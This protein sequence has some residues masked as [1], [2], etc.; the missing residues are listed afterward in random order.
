MSDGYHVNASGVSEKY[1]EKTAK[2][3]RQGPRS[4][5]D[6][7]LALKGMN[8]PIPPLSPVPGFATPEGTR[9]WFENRRKEAHEDSSPL[10][11]RSHALGRTGLE[12]AAVGFG[13]YRIGLGFPGQRLALLQALG[14]TTNLID[15]STNYG[16][17]EAEALIG[18]VLREALASET[19]RRDQVILVTKVGYV[20]GANQAI[21]RAREDSG[22]PF[23]G[24]VKVHDEIWHCI[25]PEW[26]A[27]Q[28]TRSLE[29][30]GVETIDCLLLHNPEYFLK[31]SEDHGEYYRRIEVAFV[32]LEAEIDRGRIRRYG[33]SSNTFPEDMHASD[34]T[35]LAAVLERADAVAAQAGRPGGF[36]VIQF[37]MNVFEPGGAFETANSGRTLLELARERGLAVL[38][39]RPLNAFA[40]ER[41][42]RLADFPSHEDLDELQA[43]LQQ[44]FEKAMQVEGSCPK[45]EELNLK[46]VAWAHILRRNIARIRD[47]ENWKGIR[48]GVVLPGMEAFLAAVRG[49]EESSAHPELSAW[50]DQYEAA[51]KELVAVI[52]RAVESDAATLARRIAATLDQAA[53]ALRSSPPLTHKVIRILTGLPA[54]VC[55]LIGMRSP[56]YVRDVLNGLSHPP[57]PT[58]EA[59]DCLEAIQDAIPDFFPE[60]LEGSG[61]VGHA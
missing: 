15:T 55:V 10:A 4:A 35:S 13:S 14:T 47:P 48:D 9:S 60:L 16:D 44:T 43:K 27:D 2:P 8:R 6:V 40:G 28:I 39:N 33:I 7:V 59:M 18:E 54:D 57:L 45:K 38:L 19:I 26:I 34:F 46:Q 24:M 32:Q 5:R 30:L 21:A 52:T 49:D 25:S 1:P 31:T 12:A 58:E 3:D 53:N 11:L 23:D 37:P 42:I 51:E 56:E 61:P 41:L 29:R 50:L 36:A 17:G 22:R 20:Q